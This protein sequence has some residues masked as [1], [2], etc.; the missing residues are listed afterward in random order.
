MPS[1]PSSTEF[2]LLFALRSEPLHGYALLQQVAKDTQDQVQL[3]PATLY[4]TLARLLQRGMVEE[5][6]EVVNERSQVR[7]QYRIT[8]EGV[9]SVEAE[10]NRF[11]HTLSLLQPQA[12]V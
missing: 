10:L 4:T 3:S 11:R 6:G 9:K 2:V 5:A 8:A 7:K 1:L 12:V